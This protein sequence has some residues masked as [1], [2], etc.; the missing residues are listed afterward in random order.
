M[1]YEEHLMCPE[2][3][4]TVHDDAWHI[5]WHRVGSGLVLWTAEGYMDA[6]EFRHRLIV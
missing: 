3:D 6:I 4:A 2:E 5:D 1:A